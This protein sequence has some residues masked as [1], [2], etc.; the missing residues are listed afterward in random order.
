MASD[1]ILVEDDERLARQLRRELLEQ[2]FAVRWV[3]SAAAA[4]AQLGDAMPDLVLLDLNLPDESGYALLAELRTSRPVPII[5]LTARL[6]GEDK[7][8]ALDL[9]ADDYVT[10]PFWTEEL[11]ARIRA[12]LRRRAPWERPRDRHDFGGL[13]IDAASRQATVD[14]MVAPLTATEF[15]LLHYLAVRPGRAVHRAH[16]ISEALPGEESDVEALQAHMSR[17]RRKLGPY[18]HF[19][20]TVRGVGYRFEVTVEP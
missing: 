10:K 5:V 9:G 3:A 2:G 8:R 15:D 16:L 14:G 13:A 7:V 1:L 12:V 19:I 18:A 6:L 11:C 17:L 20:A 4:R